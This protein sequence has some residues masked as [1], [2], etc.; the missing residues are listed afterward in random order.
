MDTGILAHGVS[1]RLDWN[2]FMA[3]QTNFLQV[4]PPQQI[5]CIPT[6]Y[7]SA[8]GGPYCLQMLC[9]L[10]TP[11]SLM[12]SCEQGASVV[13]CPQAKEEHAQAARAEALPAGRPELC[14]TSRKLLEH[15]RSRSA[16][17][18]GQVYC[19]HTTCRTLSLALQ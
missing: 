1:G 9:K 8:G 19:L 13:M 5:F 14:P 11:A 10:L 2:E 18:A 7:L 6:P 4:D 17:A 12:C 16:A 3:R 15:I